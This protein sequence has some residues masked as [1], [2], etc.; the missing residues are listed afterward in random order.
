MISEQL[1]NFHEQPLELS[2]DFFH[3]MINVMRL[4]EEGRVILT[5]PSGMSKIAEIVGIQQQSVRLQWIADEE[6]N[7]ELPID[8]VIACGLPKG[9]KL[10]L[11][12]QKATELGVKRIIP[13]ASKYSIVK[14]DAA[15]MKKKQQRFQ[16]IALEAA[17]QSHRQQVPE[18][19]SLMTIKDLVHFSEQISHKLVAYEED[20]KINEMGN[21]ARTLSE[22][23]PGETLL[24]VFGPEGGLATEEID[25]FMEN[26][27]LTCGLGPRILRTETAPLYV[28]S[29][30]SYHFELTNGGD[31]H[32]NIK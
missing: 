27:F 17:E 14:W 19:D 26:G 6:R 9:D 2:G 3:H 24:I 16:K 1:D 30:V 4:K 23:K 21:F 12:V 31:Y 11:I 20:A 5:D 7:S 10:D 28:L 32:R 8:V 22:T 18:I 29:A 25:L 13:F 15:K